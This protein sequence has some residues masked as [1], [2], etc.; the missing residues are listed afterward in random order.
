MIEA[1]KKDGSPVRAGD[2]VLVVSIDGR[3]FSGR[4]MKITGPFKFA[5][6]NYAELQTYMVRC[7]NGNSRPT[8]ANAIVDAKEI[9]G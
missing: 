5:S 8:H 7:S 6:F 2:W 3:K 1:R 9:Y 4:V